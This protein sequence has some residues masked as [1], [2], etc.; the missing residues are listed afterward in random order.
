MKNKFISKLKPLKK[1]DNK[2]ITFDIETY[3]KD[4]VLHVFCISTYDGQNIKSFFLTDYKNQEELIITALK[5][6]LLRKYNGYNVYMHNLA[7]FDIIFLLKY[8][9]TLGLVKPII[10]NDRIISINLNYGLNN[11]YRL[12]FRDSYLILLSSLMKLCKSFKVE[13]S[14]SVFPY[15][16]VN[17]NNLNYEGKIPDY[18]YFDNRI[19]KLDYEKYRLKFQHK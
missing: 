5:S 11:N 3:I 10:H 18:R 13:T 6:I 9:V 17:E 8:L 4:S 12:Q 14:K 1:F 15:L 16:F 19:S 7:K 2:F